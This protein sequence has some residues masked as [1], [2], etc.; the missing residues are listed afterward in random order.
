MDSTANIVSRSDDCEVAAL[1]GLEAHPTGVFGGAEAP[2][3]GQE[4]S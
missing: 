4:A 3:K 2:Q 1:G